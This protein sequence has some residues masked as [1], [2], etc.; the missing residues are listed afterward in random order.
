[1]K[2]T[3]NNDWRSGAK[4]HVGDAKERF[5]AD[6]RQRDAA[7]KAKGQS[8]S[9]ILS[10]DQLRGER[11][12]ITRLLKTTLGGKSREITAADLEAFRRNKEEA[13]KNLGFDGGG[14]T[15]RDVINLAEH[16]ALRYKTEPGSDITKA[17]NEINKATPVSALRDEVRFLTNAG[18]DSKVTYHHVVIEFRGY[19]TAASALSITPVGE[20]E[21]ALPKIVDTL[22][23]GKLAFDC[24]CERHRYFL[25]Y[26]ATIG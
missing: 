22:K 24:D 3:N 10:P 16:G 11:W 19:A 4:A 14:I 15:A 8:H 6:K 5:R 26:V 9:I 23:K 20:E 13:L 2:D 25:R 7:E 21:K 1:M 12:D 17:R 18:E